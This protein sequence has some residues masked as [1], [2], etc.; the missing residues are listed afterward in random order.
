MRGR[1]MEDKSLIFLD[2]ET[3]FTGE[4]E[5]SNIILHGKVSGTIRAERSIRLK[6]GSYMEGEIFTQEFFPEKGSV[7][8]GELHM[9]SQPDQELESSSEE[10]EKNLIMNNFRSGMNKFFSMLSSWAL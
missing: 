8:D 6:S 4:I 3:D 1:D 7:Y 5:A 10:K 2:E 9:I